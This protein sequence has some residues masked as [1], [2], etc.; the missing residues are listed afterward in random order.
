[1]FPCSR[2]DEVICNCRRQSRCLCLYPP[3]RRKSASPIGLGSVAGALAGVRSGPHR[4]APA[5]PAAPADIPAAFR[6][7]GTVPRLTPPPQHGNKY[8]ALPHRQPASFMPPTATVLAG[9]VQS[10]GRANDQA[11]P[12]GCAGQPA[13]MRGPA[14]CRKGGGRGGPPA[15]GLPGEQCVCHPVSNRAARAE[16]EA[17]VCPV[18]PPGWLLHPPLLLGTG[19]AKSLGWFLTRTYPVKESRRKRSSPD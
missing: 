17:R 1:M 14:G 8:K 19:P 7:H 3:G 9:V 6:S 12:P 13:G 4:L 15:A 5:A 18:F 2:T 16:R 11:G 10:S